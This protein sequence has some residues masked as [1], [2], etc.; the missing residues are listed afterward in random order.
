MVSQS[1]YYFNK[2]IVRIRSFDMLKLFAIFLVIWG[3]SILWFISSD[4]IE[5]AIYRDL[6]A[7]H[8]ATFMMI[9][10]YFSSSSMNKDFKTFFTRK[11]MQLIYP[12][13][14]WGVIVWISLKLIILIRTGFL[15][16]DILS[17]I[18][19]I[20]WF[21]NF[22]F[23]RSCFICYC[24][25]YIFRHILK[26]FWIIGSLIISQLIFSFFVPFMYPCFLVG[27]L[28]R[29]NK[30][31]WGKM[32][33]L[34]FLL[35]VVFC[36]MLFLWNKDLWILSHGLSVDL[37]DIR[38]FDVVKIALGRLY[39]LLLGMVGGI[40]LIFIFHKYFNVGKN[41]KIGNLLLDWGKY[42][43]EIY[44]MQAILL[45]MIL[46]RFVNFD[47]IPLSLYYYIVSPLVSVIILIIC[48]SLIK[49]FYRSK[50]LGKLL[51]YKEC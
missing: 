5:S 20:Y 13:L 31:L 38:M 17:F 32:L 15:G 7:F 11:F 9:S 50:V 18:E 43:L 28:L 39:R 29:E 10:G 51:F 49:L 26:R 1:G 21:G 41:G 19:D 46:S 3:H 45:E 48:I 6:N 40:S 47:G 27:L 25:A 36:M 12:C 37:A 22:W 14:V 33:S 34:S 44:I 16:Y 35:I 8:V 2:E 30:L 4:P 24:L 42:T 23:L